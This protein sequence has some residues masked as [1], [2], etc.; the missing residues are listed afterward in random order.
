[1]HILWTRGAKRNLE[2]V[3]EYIAKDN[4]QAAIDVVLKIIKSVE[5]LADNPAMGRVGRVFSTRELIISRTPYIVP[6]RVKAGHI[7]ILRVL[8]SA[9]QWPES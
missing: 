1:M 7:E 8:H 6:Y 4:P 5:A 3:E 2:Q 9:M